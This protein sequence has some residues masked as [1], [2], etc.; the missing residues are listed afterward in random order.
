[1]QVR[2]A[3]KYYP[4]SPFEGNGG[5]P[6]GILNNSQFLLNLTHSKLY[7]PEYCSI[8]KRNFAVNDRPYNPLNQNTLYNSDTYQC[9]VIGTAN[10]MDSIFQN[11]VNMDTAM[12][13]ST[14][15]E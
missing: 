9:Q 6:S 14:F 12:G 3:G 7:S 1:M 15:H 11:P 13:Q 4:A 8:N 2:Y 10:S 5:N